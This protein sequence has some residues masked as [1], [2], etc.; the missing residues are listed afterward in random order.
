MNNLESYIGSC[1]ALLTRTLTYCPLANCTDRS[2]LIEI[3][4]LDLYFLV[5]PRRCPLP[6]AVKALS[7]AN[8]AYSWIQKH[9]GLAQP[10][11]LAS[12]LPPLAQDALS[13]PKA[14]VAPSTPRGHTIE[15]P[16]QSW[17]DSGAQTQP[18]PRH[19]VTWDDPREIVPPPRW[20]YPPRPSSHIYVTN[21]QTYNPPGGR[22]AVSEAWRR[23]AGLVPASMA[24]PDPEPPRFSEPVC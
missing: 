7:R 10:H 22:M 17:N 18:A 5:H 16:K 15:E 20:T 13:A 11:S 8:D 9:P 2:S 12:P 14:W 24:S 21:G 23:D 19:P 1:R 6:G 4:W 3:S